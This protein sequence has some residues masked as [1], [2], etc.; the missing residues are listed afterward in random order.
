MEKLK[1]Q[2]QEAVDFFKSGKILKAQQL[3]II[4]KFLFQVMTTN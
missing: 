1:K 3:S 2:I 4:F